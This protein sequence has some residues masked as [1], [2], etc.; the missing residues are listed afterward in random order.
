MM[1]ATGVATVA[2]GDDVILFTAAMVWQKA[3]LPDES[4]R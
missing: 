1:D 2:A 3:V 4:P